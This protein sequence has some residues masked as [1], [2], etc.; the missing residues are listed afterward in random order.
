[1][2]ATIPLA[3]RP[4]HVR[5]ELVRDFD[6]YSL[7]ADDGEYQSLL[8]RL[9]HAPDVPDVFW[10]PRNGGH[11]VAARAQAVD[12]VLTKHEIFSSRR[13][14]VLPGVDPDPPLAPLQID[15]PDHNKYRN[16]LA[17]ALSPQAMA[18]LGERART[19]SIELIEGF[20]AKGE[21]EFVGDFASRL[22][23]GIFM[24]MVDLPSE[25]WPSLI[26]ISD[27]VVR[28]ETPEVI[29]RARMQMVGYAMRKIAERR[30]NPGGDLISSLVQA[31]VDGK[32]LD[33]RTLL[34]MVTLLLLA[35]LDTVASTMGY[36]ARF[37]AMNPEYRHRLIK[38]PAAIPNAVEELLRRFPIA[39]LGRQI[40]KDHEMSGA[41]L[42]DGEMILIPTVAY[43]LDDRK[44]ENP[45]AVDIDRK[46][47]IH[48]TFGGGAHRCMGSMLAR[49]ELRV[50]F[51]EWL[52]R[53]PDFQIKPGADV[54]VHPGVVASLPSLPLVWEV[55]E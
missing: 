23:V 16:L 35:G 51:E 25:D 40:R 13:I 34:G 27:G 4:A 32:P 3:E 42:K 44:F 31:E 46:N 49:V 26:A 9:L 39:N 12:E 14:T 41:S 15:P 22:P 29:E 53:I 45:E 36:F 48:A 33:D 54:R 52:A 47:K 17:P 43:G 30:A 20:K 50:F 10:T 8:H 6:I 24:T 7:H 28:G 2:N 37:L 18:V 55:P 38:E 1:M 21:C 11:W 5:P 19:L